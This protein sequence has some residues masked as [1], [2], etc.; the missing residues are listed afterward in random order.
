MKSE[1]LQTLR[2]LEILD[3]YRHWYSNQENI[4]HI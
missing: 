4:Y 1:S 2:Q 3:I